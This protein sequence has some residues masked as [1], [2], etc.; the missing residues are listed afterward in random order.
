MAYNSEFQEQY[1]EQ[2]DFTLKMPVKNHLMRLDLL[3][4]QLNDDLD[5]AKKQKEEVRNDILEI[6]QRKTDDYEDFNKYFADEYQRLMQE[7]HEQSELQN[8]QHT[9]LRQQVEQINQDR[10]KLQ[11]NVIVLDNRVQDAE[12]ELGFV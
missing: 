11:Q 7:F 1:D 9:F 12:K 3:L 10:I 8:E 6:S 2:E 4:Q 5:Y